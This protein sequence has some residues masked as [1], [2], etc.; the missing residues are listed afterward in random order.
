[1][2][3]PTIVLT[4]HQLLAPRPL[5]H[6]VRPDQSG[7]ESPNCAQTA[8]NYLSAASPSGWELGGFFFSFLFA[9]LVLYNLSSPINAC[10][11]PALSWLEN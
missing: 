1:M 6:T 2:G 11:W 8:D 3:P 7:P 5:A 9:N 10:D 4:Q